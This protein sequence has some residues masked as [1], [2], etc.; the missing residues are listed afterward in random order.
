MPPATAGYFSIAI[1]PCVLQI[2]I[3]AT[4]RYFSLFTFHF[5]LYKGLHAMIPGEGAS[6]NQGISL[7][8][9]FFIY[10]AGCSNKSD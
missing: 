2:T 3:A 7:Q 10:V 6:D 4:G 1:P 5:S 9:M 8:L